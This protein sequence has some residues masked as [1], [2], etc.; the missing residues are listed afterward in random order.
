M[1]QQDTVALARVDPASVDRSKPAILSTGKTG[2]FLTGA[3]TSEFYCEA[4][5]VRK[6]GWT[7]VRELRGPH[8]STAA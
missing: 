6:S 3:E 8:F 2:H 4:A 5:S 7:F 1:K